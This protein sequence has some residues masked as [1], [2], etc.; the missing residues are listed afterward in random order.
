MEVKPD[1]RSLPPG[2]HVISIRFI[3]EKTG[4][5]AARNDFALEVLP[6]SLP[7]QTLIHTEWLHCDCIA[8]YYGVEVFSSPSGIIRGALSA[9]PWPTAST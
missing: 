9:P 1:E 3:E 2:K 8:N 7:E 4:E 5:T 6:I